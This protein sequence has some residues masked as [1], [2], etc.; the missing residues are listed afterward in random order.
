MPRA[1]GNHHSARFRELLQT[2]CQVGCHTDY[3]LLLASPFHDEVT[4]H[5]QPGRDPDARG[6]SAACS[7]Q[8]LYG[9][10]D[11]KSG[12]HSTFGV[13]LMRLRPTKIDE[14]TVSHKSRDVSLEAGHRCCNRLVVCCKNLSHVLR[15][16]THRKGSRPDEVSEHYRQMSALCASRFGRR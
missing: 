11:C 13:V 10:H 5:N 15:I 7:L 4:N 16:K 2:R 6:K 8:P 1:L 14:D 3:V 9:F 12:A